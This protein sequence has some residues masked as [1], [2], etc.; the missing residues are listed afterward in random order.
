MGKVLCTSQDYFPCL[1]VLSLADSNL[2]GMENFYYYSRMTKKCTEK[3]I[4]AIDYKILFPDISSPSNIW[5]KSDDE[6]DE[7]ESI[8]NDCTLYSDNICFVISSSWNERDKY[9]NTDYA[10]NGWMLCVITH[11]M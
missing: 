7:E 6:I 9:I 10:V 2:A 4:S 11:I 8:S 3:K 1:I 5:N